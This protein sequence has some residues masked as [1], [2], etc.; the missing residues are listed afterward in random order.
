MKELKAKNTKGQNWEGP[1]VPELKTHKDLDKVMAKSKEKPILIFKHSTACPINARAAFRVNKWMEK[2]G[3][4]KPEM[5]YVKVIESRPVSN[6]LAKKL[7]VKHES[8]QILLIKDGESLWDTSHD[9]ITPKAIEEAMKKHLKAKPDKPGKVNAE[10]KG[11]G[12][13]KAKGKDKKPKK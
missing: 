9:K 11:Q 4:K 7:K 3:D 6:E 13:G 2:L 8:P 10:N 12:K 1:H 5:Y